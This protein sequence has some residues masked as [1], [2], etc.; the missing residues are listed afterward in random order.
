M[1]YGL[2]PNQHRRGRGE[3]KRDELQSALA[4]LETEI[5]AEKS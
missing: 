3:R 5:Y 1:D 4:A 2:M